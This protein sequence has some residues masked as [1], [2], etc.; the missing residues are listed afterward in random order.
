MELAGQNSRS[1]SSVPMSRTS[2]PI[3]TNS[4]PI[5]KVSVQKAA[6][7]VRPQPV[8]IAPEPPKAFSAPP[9]PLIGGAAAASP[10]VNSPFLGVPVMNTPFLPPPIFN[11]PLFQ[12]SI[13]HPPIPMIGA[14]VRPPIPPTPVNS[15]VPLLEGFRVSYVQGVASCGAPVTL[16]LISVPG[17]VPRSVPV[18]GSMKYTTPQVIK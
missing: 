18:P 10:F 15:P 16:S 13:V 11:Q 14:P 3:S 5:F 2:S 8:K 1:P 9:M 12:H 6:A 4:A 17:S 7:S